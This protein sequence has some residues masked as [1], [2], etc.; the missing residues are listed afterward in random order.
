MF[1]EIFSHHKR[2]EA[3]RQRIDAYT[4]LRKIVGLWP[5]YIEPAIDERGSNRM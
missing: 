5:H 3:V 4:G 2:S 1:E